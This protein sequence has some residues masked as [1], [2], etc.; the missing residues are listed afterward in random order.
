[1]PNTS[2][3]APASRRDR[4]QARHAVSGGHPREQDRERAG[5]AGDLYP[6]AAEER[7]HQSR[8]DGG[9]ESLL[10]LGTRRDREGHR[11]G[12]GDDTNHHAANQVREPLLAPEQAGAP[13]F[14]YRGSHAC[15]S[16][17]K[18]G[19]SRYHGSG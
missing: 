11:K 1:M 9:V 3:I 12:D 19:L 2:K 13:G 16:R 7:D 4:L 6:A 8:H 15:L 10:G 5:G 14:E 18:S 17:K